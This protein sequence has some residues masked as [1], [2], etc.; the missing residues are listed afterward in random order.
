[1][2]AYLRP[3]CLSCGGLSLVLRNEHGQL[4]D[5]EYVIWTVSSAHD[6][7][8]VS[9]INMEAV[10]RGV[11]KYYA[12]WYANDPTGAYEI[13]W[14]YRKDCFSSVE[15][16]VERFFVMDLNDSVKN[17]H[18]K[19]LPPPGG[20]VFEPGSRVSGYDLTLR[21]TGHSGVAQDGYS[22]LWRI[23]CK[24]GD[25]LV[26]WKPAKHLSTGEYGIDWVVSAQG[27][28]YLIRWQ[29]SE[30]F[31]TP[32]EQAVDVFQVVNPNDPKQG[33]EVVGYRPNF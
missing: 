6:G 13:V 15:K 4:Q 30:S 21:L 31:D 33:V 1:M 17:G 12:P 27:G 22:V 20:K 16:I 24:S 28:E 29:W 2:T 25:V 32:L 14:Q 23:E 11:G 9:G 18:V 5:A 19:N 3:S 26:P 8:R 10:R 7:K